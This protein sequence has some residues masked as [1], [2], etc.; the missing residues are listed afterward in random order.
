[1]N[2]IG[3]KYRILNQILPLF[4]DN[5]NC[6]LDLFA[7]GCNVAVNVS[8][9][10]V[11]CNDILFYI[12]DLYNYFKNTPINTLLNQIDTVIEQ[13]SLSLTNELGYKTLRE[14]YNNTK[15][16][17]LFFILIC[18]SFNHQIR[19]NNSH[20]FTTPFGKERS[21]YNDSIKNNLIRFV[22]SIQDK[23]IELTSLNFKQ[24]DYSFLTSQDFVYCDPP[25]LITVGSYNDGKRGFEGWSDK[26]ELILLSLLDELNDKNI[27]FALSNVLY[28]KGKANNILLEWVSKRNYNI[29]Y[30]SMN[31][32]NS[33]YHIANTNDTSS[34]EV[35]ITNYIK[36]Q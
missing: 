16:P 14:D 20:K 24:F 9:K 35:L 33:S 3:G 17:L 8:A 15:N 18:Y 26:E 10:R 23:D 22:G 6:F 28:H 1:M 11:I 12:I 5:I 36:K 25:Y 32:S 19:Y 2:Y 30:L 13:Y 7:G 34:V 29:H 27:K 31:Y 4:P 21:R